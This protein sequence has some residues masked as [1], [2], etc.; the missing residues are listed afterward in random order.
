MG[1][2]DYDDNGDVYCDLQY[3]DNDHKFH[4]WIDI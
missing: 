2:V 1:N 4:F 3:D